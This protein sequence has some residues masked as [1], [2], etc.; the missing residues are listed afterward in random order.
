M[1]KSE[2]SIFIR[3]HLAATSSSMRL[4][5]G[6]FLPGEAG[7]VAHDDER[8]RGVG[9]LVAGEHRRLAA[10]QRGHQG[11]WQSARGD[12]DVAALDERLAGHVF[13]LAVGVGGQHAELL[14]LADAL[15]D[16]VAGMSSIL[17]DAR[18]VEFS[19]APSAIQ[20]RMTS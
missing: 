10:A 9:P 4:K 1:H 15:D 7:A 6:G 5:A 12:F 13:D 16:R 11:P 20:L 19:S 3:C 17:V 18:R 8:R 14:L 2:G